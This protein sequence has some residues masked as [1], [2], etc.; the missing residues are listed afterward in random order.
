[1]GMNILIIFNCVIKLC[2][3]SFNILYKILYIY[4]CVCKVVARQVERRLEESKVEAGQLRNRLTLIEK[5]I[6]DVDPEVKLHRKYKEK[7]FLLIY[8]Y[9]SNFIS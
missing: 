7:I 4:I 8:I 9:Y 3:K 5:N 6:N 2:I 1:M